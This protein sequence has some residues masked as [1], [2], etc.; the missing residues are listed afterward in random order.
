[1]EVVALSMD[2]TRWALLAALLVAATGL[3]LAAGSLR[4]QDPAASRLNPKPPTRRAGPALEQP[5]AFS[6]KLHAGTL[7]MDCAYCHSTT[8]QSAVA[9]IPSVATCMGCHQYVKADRP[10]IQKLAA[11]FAKG[12]TIPWK[13]VHDLPDHVYFSHKRHV[14]KGIACATCH[15]DV[16]SME[17]VYPVHT[18]SMGFCVTCHKQNNAEMVANNA[19]LDCW[20]CHK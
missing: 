1:V 18:L 17:V 12:Q 19:A 9:N 5:I 2:R 6:H 14:K 16:R 4:A 11:Y 7:G 8:D 13:N 3:L 15:G 20:T 10:E